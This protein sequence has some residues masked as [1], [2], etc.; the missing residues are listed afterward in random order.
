MSQ[1]EACQN[2]CPASETK[3]FYGDSIERASGRDGRS[4]SEL[5]NAFRYRTELIPNCSCT[6]KTSVGLASVSLEQDKTLRAGDLVADEHGVL[7]ADRD[8]RNS[9]FRE[10]LA[11]MRKIQANSDKE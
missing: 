6:G 11:S 7:H 3:A 4:Y 9:G 1:A 5:P 10:S 8:R 2:F